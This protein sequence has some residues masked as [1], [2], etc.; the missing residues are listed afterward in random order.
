M[1]FSRIRVQFIRNAWYIES[2][3]L[4]YNYHK[5]PP[6]LH[7]P[8]TQQSD[9]RFAQAWIFKHEC[10]LPLPPPNCYEWLKRS[11]KGTSNRN[12]F[13]RFEASSRNQSAGPMVTRAAT[14]VIHHRHLSPR[15][16][17]KSL[18]QTHT[19][20]RL[21]ESNGGESSILL[22]FELI[23]RSVTL[24]TRGILW[25]VEGK[26]KYKRWR[27][28]EG[29]EEKEGGIP[30]RIKVKRSRWKWFGEER[31]RKRIIY[32]YIYEWEEEEMVN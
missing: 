23:R 22:Q 1:K 13:D 19:R 12:N 14:P 10:V 5:T 16:N 20:S 25:W 4:A 15:W 29:E 28:R 30:L 11:T 31:K 9:Q 21:C 7:H 26:R 6:F 8:N 18:L 24:D 2:V 27:R 32:I 17:Y 3:S